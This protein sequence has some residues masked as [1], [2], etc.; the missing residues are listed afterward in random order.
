[1]PL[2]VLV[3]C[4]GNICRS[5][6]GEAIMKKEAAAKG[7]NITIDSAGTSNEHPRSHPYPRTLDVCKKYNVPIKHSAR[8]VTDADYRTFDYILAAD[9]KNLS[10]L[11]ARKPRNATATV[12]LWGSY[13]DGKSISD[14]WWADDE[15]A[16]EECYQHCLKLTNAFLEKIKDDV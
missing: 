2:S 11:E 9:S 6:M 12:C 10:A 3:V 16:F 15:E 14:P 5:P 13:L 4:H 7:L 8:Q 1:M